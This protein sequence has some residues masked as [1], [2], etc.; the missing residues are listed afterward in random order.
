MLS[1][2]KIIQLMPFAFDPYREHLAFGVVENAIRMT[3]KQKI[4]LVKL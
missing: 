3:I 4:N 2:S 1:R